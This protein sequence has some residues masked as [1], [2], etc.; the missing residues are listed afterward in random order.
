MHKS[1]ANLVSLSEKIDTTSAAGKMVFRLLAVL[2]EFERD[3]ASERTRLAAAYKRARG[4]AWATPPFGRAKDAAGRLV[5][6]PVEQRAIAD[7]LTLRS[8]GLSIRAIVA[9]M[10]ARGVPTRDGGRWHIAT[11]Q[12]IL[13]RA[14]PGA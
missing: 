3:L 9:A 11:V 6:D 10:N 5:D 13:R 1:G 14:R 7:V 4:E 8:D 12:R 2:A